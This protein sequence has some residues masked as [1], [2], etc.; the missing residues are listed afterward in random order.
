MDEI[1]SCLAATSRPASE[2]KLKPNIN[3][4]NLNLCD[5]LK[6]DGYLDTRN[7]I[8]KTD[9]AEGNED[10]CE[11]IQFKQ[12][13]EKILGQDVLSKVIKIFEESV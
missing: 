8:L 6:D 3:K 5:V 7:E 1:Q 10:N 11:E 2:I 13:L 12:H 4:E 9:E